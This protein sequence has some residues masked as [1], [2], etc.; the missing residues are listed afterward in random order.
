MKKEKL[1][2]FLRNALWLIAY[3]AIGLLLGLN[4]LFL[5]EVAYDSTEKVTISSA[6]LQTIPLSLGAALLA[7][8]LS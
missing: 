2:C 4:I 5:S 3:L 1:H 7:A 6:L 8:I